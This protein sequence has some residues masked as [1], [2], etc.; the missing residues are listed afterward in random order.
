[1]F[2]VCPCL[3]FNSKI[4]R[5]ASP[6]NKLNRTRYTSRSTSLSFYNFYMTSVNL[7]IIICNKSSF[8]N[9]LILLTFNNNLFLFWWSILLCNLL[10]WELLDLYLLYNLTL[11][12]LIC[13]LLLCFSLYFFNL[14]QLCICCRFTLYWRRS[15]DWCSLLWWLRCSL[16]RW[17]RFLLWRLFFNLNYFRRRCT[18]FCEY[19]W[20]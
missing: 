13:C 6:F 3:L 19:R 12:F 18:S 8:C 10:L 14:I 17:L 9:Y 2:N 20:S 16:L 1:M 11:L 15:L 4:L 5:L 7:A